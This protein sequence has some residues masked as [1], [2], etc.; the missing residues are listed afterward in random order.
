MQFSS[1]APDHISSWKSFCKR[2]TTLVQ[3]ISIFRQLCEGIKH[4]HE[5]GL[6][7]RDV[8]PTRI[9]LCNGIIKFNLVGMPYNFKK[10]LKNESFSGHLNYSA[11]EILEHGQENMLTNK[12]DVW[13]LGCCLYY[14]STKRDPYDGSNPGEIKNNIRTGRLDRFDKDIGNDDM[15]MPRHPIIEALLESCLTVD[16]M[17]R[18]S[19]ALLI[20]IVDEFI[21][22]YRNEF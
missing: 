13:S 16:L 9:H 11:P 7:F 12:V 18:P 10:L 1:E 6:I 8:H 20:N 17:R 21:Y 5:S 3:M 14:L 2:P 4:I 15:G 19:A 22:K